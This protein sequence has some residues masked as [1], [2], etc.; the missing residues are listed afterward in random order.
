MEPV[1]VVG[2]GLSGVTCARELAAA[3]VAVRLVDRGRRVGGRMSSR[4]LDGRYVDLG[5][6]YFTVEDDGFAA[7]V[8]DW[9]TR[10]LARQWTDTLSVLSPDAEP[11]TKSGPVRWGSAGGLRSLVEDLATDLDVEL[12][13]HLKALPEA[14]AVVLA[15]PDPQAVRL[16]PEGPSHDAVRRRLDREFEPVLAL[17]ARW[18]ERSWDLDGA[19]VND[20]D[21]LSWVADD[22][23]RRGDGAPVLV[24][25][26]TPAYA[27]PHLLEPQAAAAP[28]TAAL[29]DLLGL[30]EPVETYLHRW[31]VARPAGERDQPYLLE[32][33]P[34]GLVGACGDGW[35]ATSKVETAWRS[36]RDLGRALVARLA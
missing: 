31:S 6:S 19:F 35:G 24:A 36:G 13:T 18:P 3:G 4:R 12:G 14:P 23:R 27:A 26:S 16:L 10:G 5:A 15:M 29:R 28:M 21:V 30:T 1:V 22:G 2:A 32:D 11:Q 33:T 34:T 8:A 25:H 7:V 20:H 9:E 17:S